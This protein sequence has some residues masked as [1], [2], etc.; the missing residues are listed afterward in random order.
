VDRQPDYAALTVEAAIDNALRQISPAGFQRLAEAY[1]ELRWPQ[2]YHDLLPSGRN[3]FNATTSGWPDAWSPGKTGRVHVVEASLDTH[4]AT[5]LDK[6][7]EKARCLKGAV[8]SFVF[9]SAANQPKNGNLESRTSTLSSIGI[10]R[11]NVEL[12]FRQQLRRDL[13]APR[14][15]RVRADLLKL[16][17]SPSPF[18]SLEQARAL[19]GDGSSAAF[20]PTMEEYEIPN[21]VWR[22]A[23][24]PRARKRL[25]EV[26]WAYLEGYGAAGKT[27]LCTQLGLEWL[28]ALKPV[29]YLDLTIANW[30]SGVARIIEIMTAYGGE[31][32][33]FI[34][35]NLHVAELAGGE[36]FDNWRAR[37][38]RSR[39]LLSGRRISSHPWSGVGDHLRDVREDAVTVRANAEDVFGA[40]RRLAARIDPAAAPPP[41]FLTRRWAQ[42]FRG[43]LVAF[44]AALV[45]TQRAGRLFGELSAE[46]AVD[47]VRDV[48]LAPY[49]QDTRGLEAL[50]TISA[51]SVLEI[52]T[53]VSLVAATLVHPSLASGAVV[54]SGD[55]HSLST[56]HPGLARLVLGAAQRPEIDVDALARC[57]E[58]DAKLGRLITRWLADRR[59]SSATRALWGLLVSQ[60][61][62]PNLLPES[63]GDFVQIM[64]A[65]YEATTLTWSDLDEITARNL[66][67]ERASRRTSPADLVS[68]IGLCGGRMAG[69]S[70]ALEA[71]LFRDGKPADWLAE[72]LA[73]ASPRTVSQ[74]AN[75][76]GRF[77]A[78][79]RCTAPNAIEHD[80]WIDAIESELLKN[81]LNR[82]VMQQIAACVRESPP[83][84]AALD[85]CL[86]ELDHSTWIAVVS[87]S[88]PR[89]VNRIGHI[90]LPQVAVELKHVLADQR[91]PATWIEDVRR[92]IPAKLTTHMF[93]LRR[94]LPDFSVAVSHELAR[95]GDADV[96]AELA[97]AGTA[98][99]GRSLGRAVML[100]IAC[101][102]AA[103][104]FVERADTAL[105]AVERRDQL[106]DAVRLQTAGNLGTLVREAPRHWPRLNE[107]LVELA[108][109]HDVTASLARE[110]SNAP[111]SEL[112]LM[113]VDHPLTKAVLAQVIT[114]TWEAGR[115]V[116]DASESFS[117]FPAVA[118]GLSRHGYSALV[119]PIAT[120]LAEA[121][122]QRRV[123]VW[124][125]GLTH[126]SHL[127][128]L[129][130]ADAKQLRQQLADR[131]ASSDWPSEAV[132]R[133]SSYEAAQALYSL[134][135]YGPELLQYVRSETLIDRLSAQLAVGSRSGGV[136]LWGAVS[137]MDAT[138]VSPPVW[139]DSAY[140]SELL[141]R[142]RWQQEY[143]PPGVV[144]VLLGLRAAANAGADLYLPETQIQRL[145]SRWMLTQPQT[146][147]HADIAASLTAWLEASRQR[148]GML[149]G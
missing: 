116:L 119:Q 149:C 6:D 144:Q 30:E 86:A 134:W 59:E 120:H 89:Y 50:L 85:Q 79:I 16:P 127:F 64:R 114:A 18:V 51:L 21:R 142:P 71:A 104:P 60:D 102:E 74:F 138:V 111:L 106:R 26:G 82:W 53:P 129:I 57:A 41:R 70:G 28:T 135:C 11:H 110:L 77:H 101:H 121:I 20:A 87:Q 80:R 72:S 125:L 58:S 96:W 148:N 69:C 23:A 126:A 117:Q 46:D 56:A 9:V 128:R 133:L 107:R 35:D 43:D 61:E 130:P 67:W 8:E 105:V 136:R 15:A 65:I 4:W 73:E 95:V 97:V 2:R 75:V 17:A 143:I 22:S 31:D 131:F 66:D 94:A 112:R 3:A 147:R 137:L 139:L 55:Q 40:Y 48:Y 13:A 115:P 24:L 52:P 83:V 122:V 93:H 103:L 45:R 140:A 1:A 92:T 27:V 62:W 88:S 98:P 44:G 54:R 39:L 109:D 113:L 132:M 7:I 32:V 90:G 91:L 81:G 47:Y 29:F 108:D 63:L 76:V 84:A 12:V 123:S 141:T 37:Q 124:R 68:V 19:F 42:L 14:F 5:H 36:L 99:G 38:D 146:P 33:L 49:E 145:L 25:D 78:S 10:P 100:S 118:S 34:V